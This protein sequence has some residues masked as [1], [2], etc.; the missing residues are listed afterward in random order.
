[1]VL[2]IFSGWVFL[3]SS[4]MLNASMLQKSESRPPPDVSEE[5]PEMTNL[6][7]I[8]KKRG[9]VILAL[10]LVKM[11]DLCTCIH[12]CEDKSAYRVAFTAPRSSCSE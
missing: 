2:S 12:P 1:M 9:A 4:S 8:G 5:L 11:P 7:Q 3:S 6:E 10:G